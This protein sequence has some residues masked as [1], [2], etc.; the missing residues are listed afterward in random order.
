VAPP[1]DDQPITSGAGSRRRSRLVV[2]VL[3]VVLGLGGGSMVSY[4]AT[5]QQVAPQPS[6]TAAAPQDPQTPPAPVS[7]A[8]LLPAARPTSIHIPA[9]NVSSAV[10][11]VGLNPDH[12][13][14][15]PHPG[16]LYDQPAWY[17]YSP[18]PGERGPSVI[19]GHVDSAKGGPSVFF[20]LGALKPGH[21]IEVARIDGT[22]AAFAVDSVE[23]FPKDSSQSATSTVT[24]ITRHCGSSPAAEAS[25]REPTATETI[26]WSSRTSPGQLRRRHKPTLLTASPGPNVLLVR[27]VRVPD[28]VG[29]GVLGRAVG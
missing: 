22:T 24:P 2:A 20:T 21:R 23:S 18:T 7:S 8:A 14:E 4:A 25:M 13:M 16:P 9:I 11:S 15:I 6:L 19:I 28:V 26:S 10:N 5:H 1:S 12:T 17:R 29:V 3:A 27:R